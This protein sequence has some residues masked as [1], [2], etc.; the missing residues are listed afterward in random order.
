M[1][2]RRAATGIVAEMLTASGDIGVNLI[3]NLVNAIIRETSIPDDWLK[4]VMVNIY[5][6]N[7]DALVQS[8]YRGLKL[9]DHGMKVVERVMDKFIRQSVNIHEMQFGFMPG[10]GTREAIF[11]VG[12]LQ[13]K[14]LGKNK[15]VYF[16][17]VDCSSS[18]C[19]W[20]LLGSYC[21]LE[22]RLCR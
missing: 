9:I 5:K 7:G 20:Q 6:G 19:V 10:R 18:S 8:N 15:Q 3:T 2:K 16:I 4:S 21:F 17:F 13:E 22:A 14:Y 1:V 12:Q 11:I